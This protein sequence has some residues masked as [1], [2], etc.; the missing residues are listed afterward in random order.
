MATAG[1]VEVSGVAFRDYPLVIVDGRIVEGVDGVIPL[2]LFADF[3]VHLDVPGRV[4]ELE[5]HPMTGRPPIPHSSECESSAVALFWDS[6][7]RNSRRLFA[8]GYGFVLQPD[9]RKRL[10]ANGRRLRP[11]LSACCESHESAGSTGSCRPLRFH[12]VRQAS[13]RSGLRCR[14][15]PGG[16]EPAPR[17]EYLRGDRLSRAC[18]VDADCE[19]PRLAGP[20]STQMSLVLPSD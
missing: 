2:A 17:P 7:G 12:S 11:S 13:V 10:P 18:G 16:T 15:G 1:S 8:A 14:C 20:H 6:P 3:L 9:S 5:P 4:L 19:L